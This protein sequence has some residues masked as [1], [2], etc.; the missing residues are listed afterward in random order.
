[1]YTLYYYLPS[2]I[3]YDQNPPFF[4]QLLRGFR[5]VPVPE[6]FKI[7]LSKNLIFGP[8]SNTLVVQTPLWSSPNVFIVSFFGESLV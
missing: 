5:Q 1:M 4:C 6:D 2:Y 7:L 3:I 8:F